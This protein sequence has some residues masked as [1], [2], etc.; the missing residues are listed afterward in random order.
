[1]E[2]CHFFMREQISYTISYAIENFPKYP[3]FNEEVLEKNLNTYVLS[4]KFIQNKFKF[5]IINQG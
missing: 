4:T 2:K 1:L 3:I 5:V